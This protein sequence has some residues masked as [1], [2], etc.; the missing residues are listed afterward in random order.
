MYKV[1]SFYMKHQTNYIL[2]ILMVLNILSYFCKVKKT[3]VFIK[4]F[5]VILLK[6]K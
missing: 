5:L 3:K 6:K 2:K 1:N 4:I